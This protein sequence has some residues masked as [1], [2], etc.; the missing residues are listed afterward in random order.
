MSVIPHTVAEEVPGL[1]LIQEGQ[2][3]GRDKFFRHYL[4]TVTKYVRMV[5]LASFNNGDLAAQD[6]AIIILGDL[7]SKSTAFFQGS[8]FPN[9]NAMRAY[10]SKDGGESPERYGKES[11]QGGGSRGTHL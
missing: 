6:H 1:A 2:E 7:V 10:L 11:A 4:P 5:G 3:I 8:K 9:D